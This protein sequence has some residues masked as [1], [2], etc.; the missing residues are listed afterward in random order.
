[1]ETFDI[2]INGLIVFVV[3]IFIIALVARRRM[4]P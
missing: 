2:I 1:M 4:K 3:I